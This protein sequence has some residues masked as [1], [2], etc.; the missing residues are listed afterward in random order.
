M[1][2]VVVVLLVGGG[3]RLVGE[4]CNLAFPIGGGRGVSSTGLV[5]CSVLR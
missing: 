5:F 3:G 1:G 4:V 2:V